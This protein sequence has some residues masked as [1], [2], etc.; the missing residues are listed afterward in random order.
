MARRGAGSRASDAHDDWANKGRAAI[1]Q[2]VSVDARNGLANVRLATGPTEELV[3]LPLFGASV[4]GGGTKAAFGRFIPKRGSFVRIDWDIHDDPFI[5]DYVLLRSSGEGPNIRAAGAADLARFAKTNDGGYRTW[6]DLQEGEWEFRSTGAGRLFLGATGRASLGAGTTALDLSKSGQEA[7]LSTYLTVLEGDGCELRLGDVKRALPPNT[8]VEDLLPA[9]LLAAAPLG[10]V[11]AKEYRVRVGRPAQ[12]VP[13]SLPV[14]L[15][16]DWAGDL[17]NAAGLVELSTNG[18]PLRG[19]RRYFDTTG[20]IPVVSTVVDCDGNVS[21]TQ[22]PT[23]A[24]GVDATV[25]RLGVTS[26]GPIVATSTTAV[27][28]L[29]LGS[30]AAVQSV[31]QGEV[32]VGVLSAIVAQLT[33]VV[34][35]LAANAG[36][37]DSGTPTPGPGGPAIAGAMTAISNALGSIQAQLAAAPGQP[38]A[39]GSAKVKVDP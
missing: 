15:F 3:P 12:L 5:V 17:R 39:I 7:R 38:G 34:A 20:L 6:T 1:G 33:A 19:R 21:I 10:A 30:P 8:F 22:V 25:S 2:I 29:L 26:V 23:A 37:I 18:R 14:D 4:A 9:S 13:P 31:P 24:F 16:E 36:A 27:A 11:V 28:G 32:L 35:A